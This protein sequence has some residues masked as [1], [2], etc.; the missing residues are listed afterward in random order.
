MNAGFTLSVCDLFAPESPSPHSLCLPRITPSRGCIYSSGYVRSLLLHVP[1]H[2]VF[3]TRLYH[4]QTQVRF[5]RAF[6]LTL[7]GYV[8]ESKLTAARSSIPDPPGHLSL[9]S[10]SRDVSKVSAIHLCRWA[11]CL[12]ATERLGALGTYHAQLC[13][14]LTT[15]IHHRKHQRMS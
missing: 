4:Q 13:D 11:L 9:S 1:P 10:S 8:E 2:H 5:T 7:S 12:K 15:L 3:H 6:V 14:A